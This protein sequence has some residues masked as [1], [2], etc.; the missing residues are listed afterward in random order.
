MV[1]G[2]PAAAGAISLGIRVAAA[3]AGNSTCRSVVRAAVTTETVL[4]AEGCAEGDGLSCATMAVPGVNGK[5]I[6]SVVPETTKIPTVVDQKLGGI[7][8]SIYSGVSNPLR[9][10]DGSLMAAARHELAGGAPIF[11]K[12]HVKE[13]QDTLRALQNWRRSPPGGTLGVDLTVADELIGHLQ[14]VLGYR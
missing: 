2:A 3:C 9:T 13:A 8:A 7:V 11:G 4:D 5:G 12:N 14:E 6:K 1:L 10:G